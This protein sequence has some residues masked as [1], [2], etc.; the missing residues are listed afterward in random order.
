[1]VENAK[2]L[3]KIGL[4]WH[5]EDPSK[6]GKNEGRKSAARGGKSAGP[7]LSV[8]FFRGSYS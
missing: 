8:L 4:K 7:V 1:V 3:E 2:T 5:F 6:K